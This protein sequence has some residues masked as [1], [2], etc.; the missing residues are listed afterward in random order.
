MIPQGPPNGKAIAW[1][2]PLGEDM[3]RCTN[4]RVGNSGI[5][6]IGDMV[7]SF[8]GDPKLGGEPYKQQDCMQYVKQ[9]LLRDELEYDT[10]AGD[11]YTTE[12]YGINHGTHDPDVADLLQQARRAKCCERREPVTNADPAVFGINRFR[13]NQV[14]LFV[15]STFW[16]LMAGFAAIN[17]GM[18]IPGMIGELKQLAELPLRLAVAST[19]SGEH[20]GVMGLV[21][22]APHLFNLIV[23]KVVGSNC[24]RIACRHEFSAY[25]I[26]WGAR[27]S[28]ARPTL[29]TTIFFCHFD[30][31][32]S[33]RKPRQR[34]GHRFGHTI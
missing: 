21:R 3:P 8:Y 31:A 11:N 20:D 4:R 18:R 7:I 34:C 27:S 15:L 29:L 24:Y 23:G 12:E 22:S 10:Y 19:E 26:F 16:R 33:F 5:H 17:I 32:R 13:E 30:H 25:T 14:A 28:S 6:L 9:R 2:S 1:S